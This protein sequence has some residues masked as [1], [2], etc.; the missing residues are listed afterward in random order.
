MP[1]LSAEKLPDE[2]LLRANIVL[3]AIAHAL[4]NIGKV[5]PPESVLE[6][7][8]HVSNRLGRPI[9]S[10]SSFDLL[11]Y[12]IE[13]DAP[14]ST[15]N[16]TEQCNISSIGGYR[17]SIT[18]TGSIAEQNFIRQSYA[19]ERA[20]APLF[21][22]IVRAH[23]AVLNHN[24]VGLRDAL[25]SM[26]SVIEKMT[27]TFQSADPRPQSPFFMDHVEWGRVMDI[28]T[29]PVIE[30]EKTGSGLLLPSVHLL[31]VFFSRNEYGSQMGKLAKLDRTWMPTLHKD[32]FEAVS[33][34]SVLEYIMNH[35]TGARHDLLCLFRRALC[36]FA[37]E[38]GF[39]GKH[40]IRLTG[41]LEMSFKTGRQSTGSGLGAGPSWSARAW[42]RVNM[43]MLGGMND[44]L[45]GTVDWNHSTVV[46][47][48]RLL[49]G[50]HDVFMLTL[51]T[52]AALVYSPGDHVAVLAENDEDIVHEAL[53]AFGFQ[54][55]T[56][57]TVTE[58]AWI[59]MLVD[60]GIADRGVLE[61]KSVE[62]TAERFMAL[63]SLQQ[64]TLYSMAS[65]NGSKCNTSKL[66][67]LLRPLTPRYYS[68][69]SHMSDSATSVMIVFK[70]VQYILHDQKDMRYPK[71]PRA[72]PDA[73]Q[74]P[75]IEA[76]RV[77]EE[78]SKLTH[79]PDIAAEERITI[80]KSIMES[81]RAYKKGSDLEHRDSKEEATGAFLRKR[82]NVKGVST[83]YLSTRN[84][85][86]TISVRI[87]PELSFRMPENTNVPIIMIS[88]GLGVTPFLSFMRELEARRRST[89]SVQDAWLI[90][91]VRSRAEIPF[92]SE[93]E[94]AV[95]ETR[96]MKL[97]LAISR[98]D[99]E[100]DEDGSQN[101]L[102]FRHGFPRHI[103]EL[104][105]EDTELLKRL[106]RMLK[107]GGHVY[108]C[109]KPDLEPMTRR[110]IETARKRFGAISNPHPIETSIQP[111][112]END[113]EDDVAQM[114]AERRLHFDCYNSGEP[115]APS[116]KFTRA[117]VAV[118]STP[119]SCWVIFRGDVYD[120][121]QYLRM[122]PGGPK[123]L[124]DKGGR[125]MTEDFEFAHGSENHR[126]ISMFEPYKVGAL[127]RC[128][129]CEEGSKDGWSV[130]VLEGALERRSIFLL[131]RNSFAGLK[132][133]KSFVEWRS[134]HASL[135]GLN[136]L[137]RKFWTTYEP[138]MYA[139]VSGRLFERLERIYGN[140]KVEQ[141]RATVEAGKRQLSVVADSEELTDEEVGKALGQCVDFFDGW[142]NLCIQI[143]MIVEVSNGCG[144]VDEG[145]AGVDA[146]GEDIIN[147]F[148]E[149][150]RKVY[151][152]LS[153]LK[154][155][156]N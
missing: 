70:R 114:M 141:L 81:T 117:D 113:A 99:V 29:T 101:H 28:Q 115:H 38:S 43:A 34:V 97:S 148:N 72:R 39:L 156:H 57:I 131:D 103:Q 108:A 40:R 11:C 67:L 96:V 149:G 31:D 14:R 104:V 123:I 30:G 75:H 139:F 151:E 76:L 27:V 83:S 90:L 102:A 122:H 74:S 51:E 7:W 125:D 144:C 153:S 110:L 63:A 86:Q 35:Q 50:F 20:A 60:R 17:S 84:P 47:E 150:V 1:L 65:G 140:V 3:G 19:F 89:G 56:K 107:R 87:V 66:D 2:H 121:T 32:F 36:S 85:G 22:V 138:D 142:V 15:H 80:G 33:K 54:P 111:E 58:R 135:H 23:Q 49:E 37:A 147:T 127:H 44:R 79:H 5:N 10:L 64:E 42:R 92:L 143:R 26:T 134:H 118:H 137:W 73:K 112:D 52:G 6:A 93:I 124:L 68:I 45:G 105:E 146:T 48:C 41:Y 91:G 62:L 53:E 61:T 106:W 119:S 8:W 25:I 18:L 95:C 12:N 100:L 88:F 21:E 13:V 145:D 82:L 128:G 78:M 120:L 71:S 130:D 24:D 55:K 133:P 116:A 4:Q 9:P 155:V 98:E 59:R 126:V 132:E 94:D 129:S 16:I 136:G 46:T 154:R 109:G 69:A 77:I 152:R